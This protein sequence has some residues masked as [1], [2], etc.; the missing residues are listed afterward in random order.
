MVRGRSHGIGVTPDGKEVWSTDV[1]HEL[2]HVFDVNQGPPR[3][4]A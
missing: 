2:V 3:Q 1:N 4:I